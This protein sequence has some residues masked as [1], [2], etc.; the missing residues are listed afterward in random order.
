MDLR[1][2]KGYQNSTAERLHHRTD[3][4]YKEDTKLFFKYDPQ[5]IWGPWEILQ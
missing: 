4:M 3:I 1:Q 2:I 5:C